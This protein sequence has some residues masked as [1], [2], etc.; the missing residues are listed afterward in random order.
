MLHV[1]DRVLVRLDMDTD[2]SEVIWSY[3]G[4]V[5]DVKGV[6]IEQD[7]FVYILDEAKGLVAEESDLYRVVA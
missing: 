2:E 7:H 6:K 4:Q 5:F 3:A 1:G